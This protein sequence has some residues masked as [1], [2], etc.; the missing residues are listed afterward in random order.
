MSQEAYN[1]FIDSV[2]NDELFRERLC[3]NPKDALTAWDLDKDE[4]E[5][6]RH[7]QAWAWLRA[8]WKAPP[9]W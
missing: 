6:I 8:L 5:S 3:A 1:A 7:G 2:A 9:D 4:L